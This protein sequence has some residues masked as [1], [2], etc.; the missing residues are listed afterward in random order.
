MHNHSQKNNNN[1]V[2]NE[3]NNKQAVGEKIKWMHIKILNINA[4]ARLR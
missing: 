3:A 1:N 2:K 4:Y